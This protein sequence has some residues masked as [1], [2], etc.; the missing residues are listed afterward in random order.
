MKITSK[1]YA[2]TLFEL[3]QKKSESEVDGVIKKLAELLKKNRQLNLLSDIVKKFSEIWNKE[4]GIVEAEVISRRELSESLQN[5]TKE[6]VKNKY[7]AK[8]VHLKNKVDKNIKGGVIIKV[9]DEV[10]DGS[11]SRQLRELRKAMVK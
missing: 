10:L 5:E 3:T 9:G 7:Q 6:F 1:Q 2:Q 4:N 8:E 11:V